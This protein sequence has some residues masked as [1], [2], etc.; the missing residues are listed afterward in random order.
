MS[1]PKLLPGATD[2]RSND[3]AQSATLA[4]VPPEPDV[5]D[6]P[7]S[8][9]YGL[10]PER[11]TAVR[12]AQVRA[13]RAAGDRDL[14]KALA[15]LRRPTVSA[16]A[17]NA[18]VRDDAGLLDQL[19]ALGAALGAAQRAG[20]G[21]DL[22]AL[23]AQRRALVE[24]VADRA[25]VAAGRELTPAVRAEV[26]ATLEA[27]LADPASAAA[28]RSGRL[29]RSLSFAGFGG[30]DLEGAVADVPVSA[31]GT[32][33]RAGGQ[34]RASAVGTG[35]PGTATDPER[36]RRA[37]DAEA[38]R[39]ATLGAAEARSQ[40]AHGALDDAVRRL[41]AAREAVA[42]SVRSCAE[43]AERLVAAER[44]REQALR[45]QAEA[46]AAAR[47][48]ESDLERC[49]REVHDAQVEAERARSTLD[50]LRRR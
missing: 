37:A 50:R 16:Y 43:A 30:V 7:G 3:Q 25:G 47:E 26:T 6:D 19:S 8:A 49:D 31:V 2:E 41:D 13:A 29:V 5:A 20:R 40:Q 18:L 42:A 22:Q 27:A 45:Y 48:A 14:A 21:A 36:Q 4:G 1:S 10:P 23:G 33:P 17:V 9:L 34:Q 38:E 44:A 32:R 12:D 35:Q 46:A 24:A 11:F 39:R 28:V 15:V